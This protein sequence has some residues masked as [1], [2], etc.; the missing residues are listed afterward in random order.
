MQVLCL[1]VLLKTGPREEGGENYSVVQGVSSHSPSVS[2]PVLLPSGIFLCKAL[3]LPE[4]PAHPF[5]CSVT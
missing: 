3:A 5:L 2:S 4:P 1:P